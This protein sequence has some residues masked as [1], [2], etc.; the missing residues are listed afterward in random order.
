LNLEVNAMTLKSLLKTDP[1]FAG[2]AR[3][4]LPI[5][6]ALAMLA[7]IGLA[8]PA[9]PVAAADANL[10]LP[11]LLRAGDLADAPIQYP[12]ARP[13]A[14]PQPSP[15]AQAE[16]SATSLPPTSAAP[17]EPVP[18]TQPVPPTAELP[19]E[20]GCPDEVFM[21]LSQYPGAGAQY[22]DPELAVRCTADE[23]IITGNGI[24]HYAFVPITPNPLQAANHEYHIPLRPELAAETTQIPLLG[25]AGVAVNGLPFFGPN[26]AG[27]PADQA[28][29]D[30][31]YNG[32]MDYCLGHTANEYHYHALLVE[33]LGGAEEGQP[34]PI[35]GFATDGFPIYGPM[36]CLD[37]D[38][39]QVVEMQSSWDRV[40]NPRT[41]AWDAYQYTEKSA[42]EYLDRCNGRVGPDGSYRY[43]ATSDFPYIIGCYAGTP[44][45]QAGGGGGGGGGRP[46]R[47]RPLL[48]SLR[49]LLGWLGR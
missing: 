28:F 15:S 30:P 40:G 41:N 39:E 4:R 44:T 8:A 47:P 38:C 14:E 34:S 26:E 3:H 45:A 11:A 22:P 42:P 23:L 43:H 6:L 46:P 5:V 9:S 25:T 13:S 10:Y 12:T 49:D 32:I 21:D 37:L 2:A 27:V 20:D 24:P 33:C 36:G 17:T 7:P 18:A 31:V 29:G 35:I 48:D 16:P 19:P 1:R